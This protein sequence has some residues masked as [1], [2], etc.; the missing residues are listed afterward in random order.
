MVDSELNVGINPQFQPLGP[1]DPNTILVD[2][3]KLIDRLSFA[4]RYS[5]LILFFDQQNQPNGTWR[6]FF[7]KDPFVLMATIST[8]PYTQKHR[9]FLLLIEQLKQLRKD[10]SYQGIKKWMKEGIEGGIKDKHL[11]KKTQQMLTQ[12]FSL[13]KGL[14]DELNDWLEQMA[15][16]HKRYPL[17]NFVEVQVEH[18]LG[19]H[20]KQLI[21]LQRLIRIACPDVPGFDGTAFSLYNELWQAALSKQSLVLLEKPQKQSEDKK[22]LIDFDVLKRLL[23]IYHNLFGFFVQVVNYAKESFHNMWKEPGQRGDCYPDT[24]L[25]IAFAKLLEVQQEQLNQLTEI[26]L[27]FYYRSIL[28]QSERPAQGDSAVLCLTLKPGTEPLLLPAG[29][30]FTGG[31]NAKQQPQQFVSKRA[32][33]LNFIQLEQVRTLRYQSEHTKDGHFCYGHLYENAIT[34]ANKVIKTPQGLL[35]NWPLFGDAQGKELTQGLAIASPL[36]SLSGGLRTITLKFSW[37]PKTSDE[38]PYHKPLDEKSYYG[39]RFFLSTQ[40][41]WLELQSSEYTI[42]HTKT[43]ITLT[44]TLD[45]TAP[46]IAPFAKKQDRYHSRWPLFKWLVG[47]S[48]NLTNPP[49]LATI[50]IEVHVEAFQDLKLY[51]DH[52]QL[53][54]SKPFLPFGPSPELDSRFYLGSREMFAKPLDD[55]KIKFQWEQLPPKGMEHYYNAYNSYLK[56]LLPNIDFKPLP[57]QSSQAKDAAMEVKNLVTPNTFT[58][59]AFMGSFSLLCK[60]GEHDWKWK[61]LAMKQSKE[62]P[63]HAVPLFHKSFKK[64]E[65]KEEVGTQSGDSSGGDTEVLDPY[66]QY[67]TK[68]AKD[69]LNIPDP[70][71][72]LA[73]LDFAQPLKRGFMQWQLNDPKYGFGR[74]LY[75][76]VVSAVTLL[77]AHELMKKNTFSE[78]KLTL[79]PMPNVPYSPKASNLSVSYKAQ[80][81]FDLKPENS[82]GTHTSKQYPLEMYHYD[83]FSAYQVYSNRES[84]APAVAQSPGMPS[85]RGSLSLVPGVAPGGCLYLK[86]SHVQAPCHLSLYFQ[87]N[88][89]VASPVGKSRQSNP[90]VTFY[91]LCHDG[92]KALKIMSDGTNGLQCSGIV[93]VFLPTEMNQAAPLGHLSKSADTKPGQSGWLAIHGPGSTNDYAHVVYLNTQAVKVTRQFRQPWT[94]TEAPTLPA[95]NITKLETPNP[96]VATIVQPFAAGDGRG[97]E[98]QLQ[99][100]RRVSERIHTKDRAVT[101]DGLATL[102]YRALPELYFCKVNRPPNRRDPIQI[103]VVNRI[104]LTSDSKPLGKDALTPVVSACSLEKLL[105]HLR[106][107]TSP[108]VQLEVTNPIY[109]TVQVTAQLH[110]AANV[111][112]GK[113]LQDIERQ[114]QIYLS[115]WIVSELP[116]HI[117]DEDLTSS[118]LSDFFLRWP[119]VKSV[120]KLSV[121]IGKEK[122]DSPFVIKPQAPLHLLSSSSSHDI[123]AAG[124]S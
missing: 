9:L 99:F 69:P 4:A 59:E 116:Q 76:K 58:D 71:L 51:N 15:L 100:F 61:S 21:E 105:V 64:E 65:K 3:R 106:Q 24:A 66:M 67:S 31:V 44:I 114:L 82:A 8:T 17:R 74:S 57:T 89:L 37:K 72:L 41:A 19:G 75:P 46:A 2:E 39:G 12:L 108:F 1:L 47:P 91:A 10:W 62:S 78:K 14:F 93:E 45:S 52:G 90:Q 5:E 22:H 38:K 124:M 98:N 11:R 6:R 94:H 110:F 118:E 79:Y 54:V 20:L 73:P 77:N 107:H 29:T 55:L 26:H 50:S 49:S 113:I 42:H 111:A 122:Y 53:N 84:L 87:L 102:A 80:M 40:K 101:Q 109:E 97:K 120:E 60:A 16:G 28:Q 13:L 7:L 25:L 83:N 117:I 103:M 119:A 32:Q 81:S 95:G 33:W 34:K 96:A 104:L 43:D 35:R 68:K 112:T 48:F 56:N 85:R 27:N 23:Q 121:S 115:P 18:Q 63:D 86:V 30:V 70:D 92:W 123:T 36:L 88:H